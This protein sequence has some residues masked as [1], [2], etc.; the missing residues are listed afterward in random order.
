MSISPQFTGAAVLRTVSAESSVT[1][2]PV[3]FYCVIG[4]IICVTMGSKT[5][6]D[7]DGHRQ[8]C[9]HGTSEGTPLTGGLKCDVFVFQ[10][11]YWFLYH[12]DHL[13][14]II[15]PICSIPRD[16]N[17]FLQ[18]AGLAQYGTVALPVPEPP[19]FWGPER[20]LWPG[21][22]LPAQRPLCPG[23]LSSWV[24]HSRCPG[25]RE[26]C[27][28]GKCFQERS[29]IPEVRNYVDRADAF[30]CKTGL[31]KEPYSSPCKHRIALLFQSLKV[32]F[33]LIHWLIT[34]LQA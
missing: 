29:A 17:S 12:V 6:D 11:N 21:P 3:G 16:D 24:H 20:A 7:T 27:W 4:L 23:T 14:K 13:V 31:R 33:W 25:K 10:T 15:C 2:F 32:L 9:I 28:C 19:H 26:R 8:W 18:P 1:D 30:L 22:D 34:E 5:W